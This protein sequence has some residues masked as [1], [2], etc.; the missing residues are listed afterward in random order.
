MLALTRMAIRSKKTCYLEKV[1]RA[2]QSTPILPF[3]VLASR[4]V[5]IPIY[6]NPF[7]NS[8]FNLNHWRETL[9]IASEQQ[10]DQILAIYIS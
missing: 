3:Q 4:L 10:K 7:I 8:S 1:S 9:N 5:A 6:I 2:L